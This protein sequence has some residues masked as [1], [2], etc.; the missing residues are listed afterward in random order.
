MHLDA[1]FCEKEAH[2]TRTPVVDMGQH[3]PS[4]ASS[5]S[6]WDEGRI[7]INQRV[8]QH[9]PSVDKVLSQFLPISERIV[10]FLRRSLPLRE[11]DRGVCWNTWMQNFRGVEEQIAH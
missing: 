8:W 5:F 6:S 3:T 9:I 10:V 2:N 4:S 1:R 11:E 7:P